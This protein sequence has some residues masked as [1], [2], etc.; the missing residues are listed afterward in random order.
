[1]REPPLFA[2][3]YKLWW[4]SSML[5]PWSFILFLI[6]SI[7]PVIL[8]IIFFHRK[9]NNRN[10]K[11]CVF[12]IPL[13][14]V[15]KQVSK[16]KD[17]INTSTVKQ[18][19]RSLYFLLSILRL[20]CLQNNHLKYSKSPNSKERDIQVIKKKKHNGKHSNTELINATDFLLFHFI[21][22]SQKGVIKQS[23][24]YKLWN[25]L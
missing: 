20:Y 6:I 2:S 17:K 22:L 16:H 11:D 10:L 12:Q 3:H 4:S 14:L 18:L 24:K 9:R 19:G 1:M 23:L 7:D 25:S 5:S 21:L 13:L 15:E 8:L